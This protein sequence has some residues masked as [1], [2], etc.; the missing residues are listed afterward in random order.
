ME[1]AG[2]FIGRITQLGS[3]DP[4]SEIKIPRITL[5][6]GQNVFIDWFL[7]ARVA[8]VSSHLARRDGQAR[9]RQC[10]TS[11]GPTGCISR[12]DV[13]PSFQFNLF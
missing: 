5:S 1:V 6:C 8:E 9:L 7:P 2:L 10:P 12:P 3:P 13:F 11:D 4:W